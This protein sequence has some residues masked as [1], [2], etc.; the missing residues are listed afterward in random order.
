MTVDLE[1]ENDLREK[2]LAE[3]RRVHALEGGLY[4]SRHPEQ[5]NFFQTG[6][7]RKS[8]GKL[9]AALSRPQSRILDL[10]CGTGYLYLKLLARGH[11]MTGVDI[12]PEM[13]GNLERKIP[14]ASKSRSSLRVA[15]AE[16]FI[17]SDVE[18]YD[19][20]VMSAF[21]HHLYDF[22]SLVRKVCRKL[23]PGGLFWVFFEPLKQEIA[24][25]FRYFLHKGIAL[26]DESAYQLEMRIRGIPVFEEAYDLSDYQRRFGGV[27][28]VLLMDIL[29]SEGMQIIDMEKRCSRRYGLPAFFAT[30]LLGSQNTFN[31]LAGKRD[32][33]G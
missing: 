13:V 33:A 16:E 1:K 12:S 31:L 8:I 19:A 5:T 21:L 25:S 30:R 29:N 7:L 28:P 20:I 15:S 27:D 6:I 2:I 23:P 22:Q 4:L 26:L 32:P 9:G 18:T 24:S 17:E 10:G 14:V 3:N 11:C